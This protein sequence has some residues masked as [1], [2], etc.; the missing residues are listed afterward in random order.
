M[1]PSGAASVKLSAIV[2]A[3]TA[4]LIAVLPADDRRLAI[5]EICRAIDLVR[6]AARV[7]TEA[8]ELSRWGHEQSFEVVLGWI[9]SL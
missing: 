3:E 6:V 9:W 4:A 8:R 7:S 1:N 2:S 5:L